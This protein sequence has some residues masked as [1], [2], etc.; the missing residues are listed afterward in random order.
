MNLP[1]IYISI[2]L[3]EKGKTKFAQVTNNNVGKR[4]GIF[5]DNKLFS[6][7]KILEP[8][9]SGIITIITSSEDIAKEIT[10]KI[11]NLTSH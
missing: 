5:L 10:N 11:N 9:N 6:S 8:I 4:A 2:H 7:P 3:T 1:T